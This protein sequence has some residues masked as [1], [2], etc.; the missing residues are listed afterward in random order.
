MR[1]G[2]I[3]D[4]GELDEND[5]IIDNDELII[6]NT[7]SNNTTITYYAHGQEKSIFITTYV[8]NVNYF[9]FIPLCI[10]KKKEDIFQEP[11]IF[12]GKKIYGKLVKNSSDKYLHK[13]IVYYEYVAFNE[14]RILKKAKFKKIEITTLDYS[15][16]SYSFPDVSISEIPIDA[17]RQLKE[18]IDNTRNPIS[19]I[20]EKTTFCKTIYDDVIH[21]I[22]LRNTGTV[23]RNINI[24][25]EK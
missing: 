22:S 8:I 10:L 16:Y 14:G 17:L 24:L 3:T 9:N 2:T 21:E 11:F 7:E 25:Q 6:S 5:F 1:G 15:N 12:F 19:T 13:P 20:F 23:K 4:G 18:F